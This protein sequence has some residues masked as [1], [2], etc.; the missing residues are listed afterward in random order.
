MAEMIMAKCG[1]AAN[2]ASRGMAARPL[3][4]S[5]CNPAVRQNPEAAPLH[6]IDLRRDLAKAELQLQDVLAIARPDGEFTRR[7]E[8]L[9]LNALGRV[10]EAVAALERSGYVRHAGNSEG[11]PLCGVSAGIVD[12]PNTAGCPD[13]WAAGKGD[14]SMPGIQALREMLENEQGEII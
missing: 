3:W 13:C 6:L 7:A 4:C 14:K 11:L 2:A 5:D 1:H 12:G 10:S 8:N 9:L